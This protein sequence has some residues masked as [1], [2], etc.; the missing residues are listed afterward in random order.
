MDGWIDDRWIASIFLTWDNVTQCFFL[1]KMPMILGY[2]NFWEH[3]Y[4]IAISENIYMAC[5]RFQLEFK[6]CKKHI[7]AQTLLGTERY[8]QILR[9]QQVTWHIRGSQRNKGADPK[10]QSLAKLVG[11]FTSSMGISKKSINKARVCIILRPKTCGFQQFNQQTLEILS[12]CCQMCGQITWKTH[13]QKILE[14]VP[15][16]LRAEPAG[17]WNTWSPQWLEIPDISQLVWSSRKKHWN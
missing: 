4:G 9:V 12:Y 5:V 6:G 1:L 17:M 15:G 3:P 2:R 10:K 7:A 14:E 16:K 8:L 13:D 11:I